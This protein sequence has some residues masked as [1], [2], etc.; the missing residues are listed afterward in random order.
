MTEKEQTDIIQFDKMQEIFQAALKELF[1]NPAS[2]EETELHYFSVKKSENEEVI[3]YDGHLLPAS[4][5]ENKTAVGYRQFIKDYIQN[6]LKKTCYVLEESEIYND[7]ERMVKFKVFWVFF[8]ECLDSNNGKML[9]K[10]VFQKLTDVFNQCVKEVVNGIQNDSQISDSGYVGITQKILKDAEVRA[11]LN[12]Q[13]LFSPLNIDFIDNLSGEYYEKSDCESNM[14]F[15]SSEASKHLKPEDF[16]YGFSKIEF[17]PSNRRL[18]RK[19]LQ[20]TQNKLYLV[21]EA[22]ERENMFHVVGICTESVLFQKFKK[23]NVMSVPYIRVNIK[24]HM[25][26]DIFLGDI[27]IFTS[28]NGHYKVDRKLREEFMTEKLKAYFGGTEENY[29]ELFKNIKKSTEQTHGTMFVIMEPADALIETQRLGDKQYGL[30]APEYLQQKCGEYDRKDLIQQEINHLNA[31]DGCVIF[32]TDGNLYGIG[33]IL[34]GVAEKKGSPARGARYNS[35]LKY[36]TFLKK[37]SRKAMI[38]V[39]SEDGSVDIFTAD[40]ISD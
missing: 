37:E 17:I 36:L 33:M 28:I 21:L 2:C 26:W 22:D 31:I 35:A 6:T 19:L 24:R 4:V 1:I 3:C 11:A 34:D 8:S 30:P 29:K 25:Q 13:E 23:R 9:L 20:I 32:D 39:I 16:L 7:K 12:M 38:L 40:D 15:L 10:C 27:Y 14:I 18:I 5:T